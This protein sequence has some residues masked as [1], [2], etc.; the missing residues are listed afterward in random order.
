M[1]VSLTLAASDE[2]LLMD[3]HPKVVTVYTIYMSSRTLISKDSI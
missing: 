2:M 1:Y 3:M